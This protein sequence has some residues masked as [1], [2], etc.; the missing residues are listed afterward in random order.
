[1][2]STTNI[3]MQNTI[4]TNQTQWTNLVNQMY[5]QLNGDTSFTTSNIDF[6]NNILIAI[7]VL[8]SPPKLISN[9]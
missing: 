8:K 9:Y 1:M 4:I 5:P 2:Y 3:P 6:N 7:I